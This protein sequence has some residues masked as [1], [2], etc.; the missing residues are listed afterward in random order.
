M[1]KYAVILSEGPDSKLKHFFTFECDGAEE[2]G[3]NVVK[4]GEENNLE[5][6]DAFS[7]VKVGDKNEKQ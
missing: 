1:N 3:P 4:L 6:I 2:I 5:Y 7:V